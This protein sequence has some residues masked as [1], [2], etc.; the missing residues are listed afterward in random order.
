[1]YTNFQPEEAKPVTLPALKCLRLAAETI[2]AKICYGDIYRAMAPP[3]PPVFEP[4]DFTL[5]DR[6]HRRA[7]ERRWREQHKIKTGWKPRIRDAHWTPEAIARMC[8]L[9]EDHKKNR[10]EVAEIFNKEY[11]R[12]RLWTKPMIVAKYLDVKGL[13]RVQAPR[14]H[15][16]QE[17]HQH[18]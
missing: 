10:R 14:Q 6:L 5:N 13:R 3:P 11:P 9:I 4:D 17:P 12:D 15:R 2:P 7:R 16:E 1:M 18:P 8:E